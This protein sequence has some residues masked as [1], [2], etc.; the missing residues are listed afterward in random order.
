MFV[1]ILITYNLENTFETNI[2]N[3]YSDLGKAN[4]AMD[5]YNDINDTWQAY[6]EEYRVS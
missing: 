5:Y 2:I 4:T 3:V 6:V 1:Y